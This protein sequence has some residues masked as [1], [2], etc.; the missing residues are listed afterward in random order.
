MVYNGQKLKMKKIV[1]TMTLIAGIVAGAIMLSAF[2]KSEPKN[3]SNPIVA[4][5]DMNGGDCSFEV[6]D[7]IPSI[8]GTTVTITVKV[9]PTF[10]PSQRD[11]KYVVVVKPRG[12]MTHI[13][14]SQTQ[15]VE[16]SY[17]YYGGSDVQWKCGEAKFTCSVDN[18]S[19]NQCNS[20]SFYVS[21]CFE[22]Q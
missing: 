22:K 11:K 12:E 4:T 13:L 8:N 20:N 21:S 5:E 16:C 10:T 15:S 2:T 14:N 3:D 18:N 1:L 6:T 9:Q 17:G 7:A 19:Y